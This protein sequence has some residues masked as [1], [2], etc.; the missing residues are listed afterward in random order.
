MEQTK[1]MVRD[2]AHPAKSTAT[3]LTPTEWSFLTKKIRDTVSQYLY[4]QTRRSPM[5]LP[6]VIEL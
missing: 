3:A 1:D 4:A 6:L 2:R 5:V